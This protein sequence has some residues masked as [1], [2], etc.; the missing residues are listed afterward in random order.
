MVK[1]SLIDVPKQKRSKVAKEVK[2]Y[3]QKRGIRL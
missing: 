3:L 1:V 2:M